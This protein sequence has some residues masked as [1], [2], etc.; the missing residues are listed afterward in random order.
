MAVP[1]DTISDFLTR[2]RNASSSGKQKVTVPSSKMVVKI[3]EILK[4]EGYIDNLKS[5]EEEGKK[6]LRIH[7]KYMSGK[8][9]VIQSLLRISRPGIKYYVAHDEIPQVLG[10]LGIAIISTSKGIMTD[11][12]ARS[13]GIGGELLCKVW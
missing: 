13:Q 1:T 11:R 8:K 9:P 3:A 6:R 4:Q 7:L 2:I 12:Q 10:G 5:I